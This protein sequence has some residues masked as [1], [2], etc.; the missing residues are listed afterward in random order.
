MALLRRSKATY[1][2][3]TRLSR[4]PQPEPDVDPNTAEIRLRDV[5]SAEANALQKPYS[6]SSPIFGLYH[7]TFHQKTSVIVSFLQC[8]LHYNQLRAFPAVYR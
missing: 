5:N 7:I 2:Y 1:S 3:G 8:N 4:Q 6:I